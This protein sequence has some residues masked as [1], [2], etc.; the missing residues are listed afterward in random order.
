MLLEATSHQIRG[1]IRFS[2]KRSPLISPISVHLVI[3]FVPNYLF[4]DVQ[5][6]L[7][8]DR[9]RDFLQDRGQ[10]CFLINKIKNSVSLQGKDW[11]GLLADPFKDGGFLSS[12]FLSC[13]KSIICVASTWVYLH[14]APR[15]MGVRGT[16]TKLKLMLPDKT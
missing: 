1:Q 9:N 12:G 16:D 6:L 2:R 5:R 4:K 7:R 13:N 10:I 11:T 3:A 14:I 15:N 8:Q